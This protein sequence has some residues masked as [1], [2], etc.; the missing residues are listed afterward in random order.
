MQAIGSCRT[1][2][3]PLALAAFLCGT[4]VARPSAGSELCYQAL[5]NAGSAPLDVSSD[6]KLAN[7]SL[8]VA[9]LRV[10]IEDAHRSGSQSLARLLSQEY[11]TKLKQL[12]DLGLNGHFQTVQAKGETE[13]EQLF[14][15]EKDQAKAAVAAEARQL[16][17][18]RV[19]LFAPGRIIRAAF[20]PLLNKLLVGYVDRPAQVIDLDSGKLAFELTEQTDTAANPSFKLAK[21]TVQEA[22]GWSVDNMA[23]V[24]RTGHGPLQIR[25]VR[26]GLTMYTIEAPADGFA[27]AQLTADSRK[28]LTRSNAST[29]RGSSQG[30]LWDTQTGLKLGEFGEK[31]SA[32]LLNIKLNPAG[33]RVVTYSKIESGI[34]GREREYNT[35]LWDALT[36]KVIAEISNSH[37]GYNDF[38]FSNNG[39]YLM[40]S[41]LSSKIFIFNAHD[42]Q[43]VR[44]IE[45]RSL[46]FSKDG[47]N[48]LVSVASMKNDVELRNI[49]T[50]ELLRTFHLES[51]AALKTF[52]RGD[53]EVLTLSRNGILKIFNTL[54]GELVGETLLAK[55]IGE[56]LDPVI[57]HGAV[58]SVDETAILTFKDP[59][60][61]ELW[62]PLN[63]VP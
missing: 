40:A 37:S 30:I 8:E 46:Q 27:T 51:Q 62:R 4:L 61:V 33:T 18:H 63:L 3:V 12:E 17:W 21:E 35:R 14:N 25:N 57:A 49:Q 55:P 42:G 26:S 2:L 52:I 28:V 38:K 45:G 48:A 31:Q 5:T 43:L 23:L 24:D 50:G 6:N 1:I 36:G 20:H 59:T 54:T 32:I 19:H 53:S 44:E 56:S 11:V 10:E 15:R 41:T 60:T 22:W 58:L 16:P 9:K 29:D 47:S 34:I 13:R 39:H 7:L